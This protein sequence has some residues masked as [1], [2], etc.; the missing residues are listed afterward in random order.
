M[1]PAET[2]MNEAALKGN[3]LHT[4]SIRTI[5]L[6]IFRRGEQILVVEGY[7]PNKGETF[8]RPLGGGIEFGEYGTEALAREMRE[9]TGLE[10]EN[11]RYLGMCENI[12]TYLGEM[13]HE[14]ALVY[15]A[16]FA[17]PWVYDSEWIESK[18]DDNT[19]FRAVWKRLDE[20]GKDKDGPL[21]PD[22]LTELLG[23]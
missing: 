21:Y 3:V 8:F 2:H 23:L 7:D 22:G 19:P 5:V 15:S 9:E 1:I 14:I 10:I 13:G 6:G 18:E 12:F 20:F 16:D 4:K 11:L 17:E